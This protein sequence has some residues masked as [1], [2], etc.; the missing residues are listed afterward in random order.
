MPELRNTT[1]PS[2][3]GS[4]SLTHKWQGMQFSQWGSEPEQTGYDPA[5]LINIAKSTIDVP[6]GFTVH[7][8]LKKM[9]MDSRMKTIEKD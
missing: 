2:Y 9:F 3:R 5:K 8:R 7:P 4:R 1:D 6:T